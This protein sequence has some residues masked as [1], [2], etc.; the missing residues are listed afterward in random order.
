MGYGN[1]LV[2]AGL[3]DE[4]KVE[5]KQRPLADLVAA[6]PASLSSEDAMVLF[7]EHQ[8]P[9]YD[10]LRRRNTPHPPTHIHINS[11]NILVCCVF[12]G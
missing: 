12:F 1:V 11:S 7:Q 10:L 4:V 9:A 6:D 8:L 2:R 3:I 5:R